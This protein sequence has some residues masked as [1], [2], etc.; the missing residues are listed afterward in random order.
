MNAL[1]LSFIKQ[2]LNRT[3]TN[4]GAG[5]GAYSIFADVTGDGRVNALD[6]AAIQQRLNRV[7]PGAEPAALL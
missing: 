7:L 3:A 5:G 6:L 1:D 2:R 4:P